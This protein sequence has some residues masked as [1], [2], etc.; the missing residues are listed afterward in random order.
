MET[1]KVENVITNPIHSDSLMIVPPGI[2]RV[3]EF[4]QFAKWMGTPGQ[5]REIQTQKE[6]ANLVDVSEDTLSDW[7]K[8]QQFWILVSQ[9]MK[10]WMRDHVAD[11]IGGLYMK[12]SSEKATAKDVEMFLKM[13]GTEII[14]KKINKK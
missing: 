8:Y 9:E 11:A 7:K 12:V 13:A 6:F 2:Q 1:A 4:A 5:L 3:S 10:N 14:S